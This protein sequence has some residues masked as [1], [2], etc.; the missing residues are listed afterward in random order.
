MRNALKLRTQLLS[1]PNSNT[2]VYRLLN[3]EG[4][5]MS[6]LV[7]DVMEETV[8]IQSS[9][10]WTE[11]HQ[12]FIENQLRNVL[13]TSELIRNPKLIWTKMTN[14][15][16]SDGWNDPPPSTATAAAVDSLTKEPSQESQRRETVE[17]PQAMVVKE[18]GIRF[19]VTPGEGQKTGFY[20]DQRENRDLVRT[21]SN[22]KPHFYLPFDSFPPNSA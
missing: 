12:N 4:D 19:H 9:A 16:I 20:C 14:R 3:G 5:G 18:N 2:T 11:F 21:L 10:Y 8:V 13:K 1:L 22:G 15:L 17:V 6:G 7:V